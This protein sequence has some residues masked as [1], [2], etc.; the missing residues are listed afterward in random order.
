MSH[1]VIADRTCKNENNPTY[2]HSS[3]QIEREGIIRQNDMFFSRYSNP[4]D[5]MSANSS[6]PNSRSSQHSS[7]TMMTNNVSYPS[8]PSSFRPTTS[9]RGGRAAT[10]CYYRISNL[11]PNCT[12]TDPPMDTTITVST[13]TESESEANHRPEYFSFH[14]QCEYDTG[15]EISDWDRRDIQ[16]RSTQLNPPKESRK[17]NHSGEKNLSYLINRGDPLLSTDQN[18]DFKRVKS[19]KPRFMK[20][21]TFDSDDN[22][23]KISRPLVEDESS[24]SHL[25]I[26][27][28]FSHEEFQSRN[29]TVG[30]KS[31]VFRTKVANFCQE[32]IDA[33]KILLSMGSSTFEEEKKSGLK[34]TTPNVDDVARKDTDTPEGKS[35]SP[36]K[37][38]FTNSSLPFGNAFDSQLEY[39]S[40]PDEPPRIQSQSNHQTLF[41]DQQASPI[42][43]Q[44]DRDSVNSFPRLNRSFDYLVDNHMDVL[45]AYTPTK[46]F[47]KQGKHLDSLKGAIHLSQ[48]LI[49][50]NIRRRSM[51]PHQ[52]QQTNHIRMTSS[53]F[54]HSGDPHAF[55][56]N[57]YSPNQ[58]T[59]YFPGAAQ[60]PF[61]HEHES[62]ANDN[63]ITRSIGKFIHHQILN[64][65]T[66]IL[67]RLKSHN[68]DEELMVCFKTL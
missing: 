11:N 42:S 36:L 34:E 28:S 63:R 50:F 51:P 19:C 5:G 40:S 44:V 18:E 46:S 6:R 8:H 23:H 48:P 66:F 45:N 4:A 3:F 35:S 10:P 56:N 58:T 13:Y 47:L 20:K 1:P 17:R 37:V 27:P 62:T 22:C 32:E 41:F 31:S 55:T 54:F 52:W 43:N 2:T 65:L 26:L 38:L 57:T 14:D 24:Y 49:E 7:P 33:H 16:S 64:D 60:Y 67:P 15:G 29:D 30:S 53:G 12:A 59:H 61:N 25:K 68:L 39:P 21:S 9:R